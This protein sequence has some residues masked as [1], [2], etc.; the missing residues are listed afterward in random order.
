MKLIAKKPQEEVE[1]G[2]N[3]QGKDRTG[4]RGN[5]GKRREDPSARPTSPVA[6]CREK[7]HGGSP[8]GFTEKGSRWN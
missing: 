7:G 5:P 6:K 8:E 2:L 4:R 1:T 3:Y